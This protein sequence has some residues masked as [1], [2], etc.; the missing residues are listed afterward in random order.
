MNMRNALRGRRWLPAALALVLV[1]GLGGTA[2]AAVT[3]ITMDPTAQLSAGGLHATLTGTVTCDPGD[4]P[5]LSGQIVATK[6]EPGGFGSA[7]AVCDGTAQPYAIDVTTGGPF[8]F[9]GTAT[10]PFKAGKAT[11]Q[12]STSICDWWLMTCTTKYVDGEIKLLK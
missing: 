1:A 9:P 4:T 7:H 8:P 12:V 2:Q 11:A 5:N 3:N 10:G 6:N